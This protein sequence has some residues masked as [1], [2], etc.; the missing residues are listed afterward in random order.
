M[1]GGIKDRL[2]RMPVIGTALAVQ[3]RY[4][5]DAGDPLA[6][7]I[8]FF[9]FLSLFPLLALAVSAAGFVL[10]DPQDQVEVALRVTEA[11]PGFDQLVAE[12][13]GGVEDLIA[14]VV[15]QRG[16]IGL[17]GAVTLLI[18]GL[19]VIAAAMAATRVVFRGEV[20]VGA[21][22]RVR[23]LLALVGLGAL[24]LMAT[25]A[26]TITGL[27]DAF[28]PGPAIVA[29]GIAVTFAL[30]LLL[31]LGAYRLL[32]PTSRLTVR[33]LLPGAVL[34]AVGWTALKVG[35]ATYVGNQVED[36]N[37]LYGALGGVIALL[38]L[39][40]LAGRLYVYG[41]ELSAVRAERQRG[42]ELTPPDDAED[43][44]P[45]HLKELA[46]SEHADP[47]RGGPPPVPKA[48][49]AGPRPEDPGPDRPAPT[50][51]DATLERLDE[52]ERR[53]LEARERSEGGETHTA[54]SMGLAAVALAAAWRLLGRR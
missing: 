22:A 9:G 44:T 48:A 49:T 42:G 16:T 28:L 3:E 6:A 34:G 47:H 17:V 35:S 32:S 20:L 14:N 25:G 19:K 8:G 2:A 7:A 30:D 52:A 15:A 54:V 27:V 11:I 50:R 40:Y 26:S 37:A 13:D 38:L 21:G 23:Q 36:A 24:A 4:K 33:E 45:A 43:H 12:D 10:E 5:L 51:S 31:F 29:L 41:A 46:V 18:T 1:A 39:L 53:R